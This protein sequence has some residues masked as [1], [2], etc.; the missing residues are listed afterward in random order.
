MRGEKSAKAVASC[1]RGILDRPRIEPQ[2]QRKYDLYKCIDK[3][4][5]LKRFLHCHW[6]IL[7]SCYRSYLFWNCDTI[8][9][10]HVGFI[11]R[12]HELS[13]QI[14]GVLRISLLA[15]QLPVN[16]PSVQVDDVDVKTKC[17]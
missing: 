5:G 10:Q 3:E 12:S 13:F 17:C 7:R 8:L 9:L 6:L 4:G 11:K 16:E 14:P 15:T 1:V 2:S